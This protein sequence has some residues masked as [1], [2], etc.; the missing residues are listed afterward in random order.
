MNISILYLFKELLKN[1]IGVNLSLFNM[2][3]VFA[4][5]ILTILVSLK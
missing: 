2:I 4:I 5:N 1:L 3:F